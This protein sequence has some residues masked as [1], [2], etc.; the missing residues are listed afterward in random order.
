MPT[1][2]A[3]ILFEEVYAFGRLCICQLIDLCISEKGVGEHTDYGLYHSY[4]WVRMKL[5]GCKSSRPKEGKF[6]KM[7]NG[8]KH[9]FQNKIT[10]KKVSIQVIIFCFIMACIV[11]KLYLT[12]VNRCIDGKMDK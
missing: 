12:Y 2:F 8:W 11:S 5:K 1:S 3:W 4:Y 9:L 7:E 6:K 10:L